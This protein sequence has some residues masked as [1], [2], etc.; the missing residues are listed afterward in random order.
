M[1]STSVGKDNC[2][3][4][5]HHLQRELN[6]SSTF[7]L[8]FA[9]ISPIVALYSIFG[10]GILT[11]GPA[12]WWGLVVAMAGQLLVA[13]V[14]AMLV[15]RFPY[16]GSIYQWSKY[17]LGSRFGWF[18]GWTYI[19]TL[20][21]TI[22]TVALGGAGFVAQLFGID[23]TDKMISVPIAL[24]LIAFAT[25]GN[26]QGRK[27]FSTIV[28]LCIG[29]EVIGSVGIG[30]LLLV[31]FKV[32]ALSI[33]I[34]NAQVF[35]WPEP[36]ISGFFSSKVAL[37]IA[38]CGWA[39][40][41]FESAG[42]VAEEVKDPER[43]VPKAMLFCLL[44]VGAVVAFSAFSLILALPSLEFPAGS[45]PVTV[46]LITHLGQIAYKGMLVLFIIGFLACMLGIQASVSRVIWAFARDRTIPCSDFLRQLSGDDKLPTRAFL[47][48]GA[49]SALLFMLSFTN[50]YP[51][52]LAFS[53]AG[54]YLAFAFPLVGACISVLKGDWREG[55]FSL[56]ILSIPT[57]FA[58]T[59]WTLFE[60]VNISWPRYPELSWYENWAVPIM[61]VFLAMT[62]WV[63]YSKWASPY[64]THSTLRAA[65][66]DNE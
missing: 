24:F 37:A 41:G 29:A 12:F 15:S 43:A 50:I 33:L 18:A 28:W 46:T 10:I 62:G 34:P 30:V 19:C 57:I 17:L 39:F 58:A 16:E 3:E 22:A 65:V 51:L 66:A 21:I 64:C 36:G 63:I 13:L 53:I 31:E 23:A 49:L 25:W 5:G 26:T 14:F 52:L 55:P 32:N 2:Q 38:Y 27:I 48:T 4:K 6:F 35:A 42:A 20:P 56:G 47:L 9:F 54:F 59:G 7:S 60:T 44:S 45:D 40:V 1:N 8:A 11:V 61:I